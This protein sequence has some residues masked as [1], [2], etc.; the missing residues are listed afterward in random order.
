MPGLLDMIIPHG[1]GGEPQARELILQLLMVSPRE[2]QHLAARTALSHV[3]D[4]YWVCAAHV[5]ALG[6][7]RCPS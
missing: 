1:T 3:D 4:Q 5:G 7:N 6:D 2:A